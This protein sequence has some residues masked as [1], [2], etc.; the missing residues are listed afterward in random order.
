MTKGFDENYYGF[1]NSLFCIPPLAAIRVEPLVDAG[2][3]ERS[4][5]TDGE[6]LE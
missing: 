1:I 6:P 5:Q 2:H 3:G 4:P